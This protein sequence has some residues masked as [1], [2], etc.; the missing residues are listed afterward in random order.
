MVVIVSVVSTIMV[1]SIIVSFS[2][3]LVGTMDWSRVP[4]F[5]SLRLMRAGASVVDDEASTA[6]RCVTMAAWG[7][8]CVYDNVCYD[9][10]TWLFLDPNATATGG[11]FQSLASAVA[12][13]RFAA[14]V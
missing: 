10:S 2:V 7:D 9:G 11:F 8:V 1:Y 6:V 5:S 3:S 4:A 13:A 14:G 12:E